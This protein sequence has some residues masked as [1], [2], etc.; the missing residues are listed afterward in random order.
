MTPK[1]ARVIMA[2]VVAVT[3]AVTLGFVARSHHSALGGV[4][5][6]SNQ[7][8]L[9]APTELIG[10]CAEQRLDHGRDIDPPSHSDQ[11]NDECLP[12][13]HVRRGSNGRPLAG[14]S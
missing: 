14:V 2:V 5:S 12:A 4:I 8:T 3:A 7:V 11:E 9:R 6:L 1:T 10:G 13:Q